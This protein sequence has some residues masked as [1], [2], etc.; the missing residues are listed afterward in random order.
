MKQILSILMTI[1]LLGCTA[2]S[3][4]EE[5]KTQSAGQEFTLL[6]Y[7]VLYGLQNNDTIKDMYVN[8]VKQIDPDVVAYQEMNDFTQ[9][10][11]EEFASRYG[12]PY[13]VQSKLEG[14]PVALTS[15][16]PIV[17]VQKVVDNMWHAYLYANI[18]GIHTMV[19]H[20]SPFSYEKRRHEVRDVIARAALIP[21]G[22]KVAIMG[23][24]NSLAQ[25]DSPYYND[26]MLNTRKQSEV[27]NAHIR[28]LD[29]GK[30]DYSITNAMLDAGYTDI[31]KTFHK[32]FV[33][34]IG[35]KK[36]RSKHLSRI[37]YV[38]TNDKL[39]ECVT[40]ADVLYDE[41]TEQMSDHYPLLIKFKLD[42]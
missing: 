36:Y 11:L 32:D 26:D 8:W 40:S 13:A 10:S 35:S 21:K 25:I 20:F 1:A 27:K 4:R 41:A 12:H 14:F 9:K 42:Q 15:K 37:D 29:N 3:S 2:Q 23:D 24:F 17:N 33:Y 19:I 31:L 5:S 28:N 18:N 22:E 39:T 34:T 6:S 7:N 30:F 38:W 16:Y